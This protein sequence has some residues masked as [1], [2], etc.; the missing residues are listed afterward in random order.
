MRIWLS[1]L[2]AILAPAGA[3]TISSGAQLLVCD[4]N[5]WCITRDATH[6]YTGHVWGVAVRDAAGVVQKRIPCGQIVHQLEVSDQLLY[7]GTQQGLL[8]IDPQE[9][10]PRRLALGAQLDERLRH[11]APWC[12]AS[13][14][15]K[16]LALY[17]HV[18]W[19][20]T[21]R[22]LHRVD[23]KARSTQCIVGED[24][25]FGYSPLP[26]WGFAL[27]LSD[28]L[29]IEG[30]GGLIRLSHSGEKSDFFWAEHM[31][32]QMIGV[33]RE[34]IWCE[35]SHKMNDA[36]PFR[37]DRGTGKMQGFL[38]DGEPTNEAPI[39]EEPCKLIGKTSKRDL[40]FEN[41]DGKRA[42]IR[43]NSLHYLP[44]TDVVRRFAPFA[45]RPSDGG[46]PRWILD[47]DDIDD[48]SLLLEKDKHREWSHSKLVREHR[49]LA[50]RNDWNA[51][52]GDFDYETWSH[53]LIT[54]EHYNSG[55]WKQSVNGEWGRVMV[56]PTASSL[57]TDTIYGATAIGNEVWL[58]GPGGVSVAD[59]NGRITARYTTEDGL[60][61]NR[62]YKAFVLPSGHKVVAFGA[63]N[64]YHQG[65]LAIF[66]DRLRRFIPQ[67]K[68]LDRMQPHEVSGIDTRLPF[69]RGKTVPV[70][71]G[72]A[73]F[74]FEFGGKT[75]VGGTRGAFVGSKPIAASEPPTLLEYE[76]V[77]PHPSLRKQD[78]RLA[79]ARA[80]V[81]GRNA[82][83][84]DDADP[85]T[86]SRA[87][88]HRTAVTNAQFAKALRDSDSRV[89]WAALWR[90]INDGIPDSSDLLKLALD[91]PNPTFQGH[92]TLALLER[93][94]LPPIHYLRSVKMSGFPNLLNPR[95]GIGYRPPEQADFW[96]AL[97]LLID[98]D[99]LALM[100][101][102]G[103]NVRDQPR[104]KE[105]D[106]FG[107]IGRFLAQHPASAQRLT[108]PGKRYTR[109][110]DPAI[111]FAI[112]AAAS[113]G[114]AILP[115]IHP[116]LRDRDYFLRN[117]AAI[118]CRKI[119]D[120]TSLKP[121]LEAFSHDDGLAL[122]TITNALG[123]L[124]SPESIPALTALYSEIN[125]SRSSSMMTAGYSTPVWL[126]ENKLYEKYGT[127]G[128]PLSK[129]DLP[130]G[131]HPIFPETITDAIERIGAEHA[132][133]F[134]RT[135]Y[136]DNPTYYSREA[137][138]RCLRPGTEPENAENI[139]I[140]LE[141]TNEGYGVRLGLTAY[142]AAVSLLHFDVRDGESVIR[143]QLSDSEFSRAS[144]FTLARLETVPRAKRAFL[145][146]RLRALLSAPHVTEPESERL[147]KLLKP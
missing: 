43:G 131:S 31:G 12:D 95:D 17:D 15:V 102:R 83:F 44:R 139:I 67:P 60:P 22:C 100:Q 143:K 33:G 130:K 80:A 28:G 99:V 119:A 58:C 92:A 107:P 121:L 20:V 145:D 18:L 13:L 132:Q 93:G 146:D 29:W 105:E 84:R 50:T 144:D 42:V 41:D 101:E 138:A 46:N 77:P 7:A 135:I 68:R 8:V 116:W 133:Q 127:Q 38:F 125:K 47:T 49:M 11:T 32:L 26:R 78:P 74:S 9:D 27:A 62:T 65:S 56:K 115:T 52:L 36:R 142:A 141:L 64:E 48:L 134:F 24:L 90:V 51:R 89:R 112:N 111:E 75:W 96:K 120:R 123:A 63:T 35:M 45:S 126:R 6:I 57:F 71:G 122:D 2:F 5:I 79:Q 118:V 140:L 128:R 113:A 104:F 85:E 4:D 69:L 110:S 16:H 87:V 59:I 30:F 82:E 70:L 40:V 147:E 117:F 124:R 103:A 53:P 19:V 88:A 106:L 76:S 66:D 21:G 25:G 73:T 37:I 34:A 136:N 3:A 94:V 55:I 23:L 81:D 86:R 54:A 109:E 61:T 14:G 91:D 137:V 10:S 114:P 39:W 1:L 72:P 97:A 98:E 129:D 108:D